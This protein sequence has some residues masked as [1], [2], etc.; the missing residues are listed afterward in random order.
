MLTG[1]EHYE[2]I[3]K[4]A[5]ENIKTSSGKNL[6]FPTGRSVLTAR[7]IINGGS[8]TLLISLSSDGNCISRLYANTDDAPIV[9]S[10]LQADTTYNVQ[11]TY[12][13][14]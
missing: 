1:M 14:N 4:Y 7:V 11:Y 10:L 6:A 3:V 2:N 12:I 13:E 5:S 9:F 8:Y